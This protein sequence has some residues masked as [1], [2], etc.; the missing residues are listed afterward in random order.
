M[1]TSLA[2]VKLRAALMLIIY[3][4]G[5]V[6]KS[7]LCSPAVAEAQGDL[8]ISRGLRTALS[9]L[10]VGVGTDI[11]CSHRN[12]ERQGAHGAFQSPSLAAEDL[13]KSPSWP[14][15]VVGRLPLLRLSSLFSVW[16]FPV[17]PPPHPCRPDSARTQEL[18][19]AC[20]MLCL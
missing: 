13:P 8:E 9:A 19:L 14:P 1:L 20:S 2:S 10:A 15:L 18:L 6:L 11:C 4:R 7:T 17:I 3:T 12:R 5:S 16:Y